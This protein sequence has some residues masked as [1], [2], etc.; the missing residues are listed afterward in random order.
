M[1]TESIRFFNFKKK[2]NLKKTKK[3]LNKILSEEN[4]VIHSLSKDYK[5]SF[6]KKK[7]K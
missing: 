1:I 2:I 4:Q 3:N 5:S 6:I 7:N